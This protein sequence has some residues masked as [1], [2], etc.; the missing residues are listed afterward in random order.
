MNVCSRFLWNRQLASA[1][2]VGFNTDEEGDMRNIL[3]A[4]SALAVFGLVAPVTTPA[5]AEERVI[6]KERRHH[7]EYSH[8]K[9]FDRFF[10]RDHDRKTVIIKKREHREY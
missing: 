7:P 2:Y 9:Y 8:R 4:L 1:L 10:N 6:I 5:T 3:L